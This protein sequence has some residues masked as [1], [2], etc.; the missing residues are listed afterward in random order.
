VT[1]APA[2][3]AF[4]AIGRGEIAV[5]LD[6]EGVGHLLR[7]ARGTSPEDVVAM[8]DAGGG[9]FSVV[10]AAARCQELRI[11]EQPA[12]ESTRGSRRIGVSVDAKEGTTTGISAGDR[13]LT[14]QAVADPATRASDLVVPGHVPPLIAADAGVLAGRGVAEA[15]LDL[16]RLAGG[17]GALAICAML[18]EDG[19][20]ETAEEVSATAARSGLPLVTVTEIA[21]R[22]IAAERPVRATEHRRVVTHHGAFTAVSLLNEETGEGHAA[23]VRGEVEGRREVPLAIRTSSPVDDLLLSLAPT[24]E[25]SLVAVLRRFARAESGILIHLRDADPEDP[26]ALDL[27]AATLLELGPASVL[28]LDPAQAAPLRERGIPVAPPRTAPRRRSNGRCGDFDYD[29]D[30]A[31]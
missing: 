29:V 20:T 15:A 14:A 16:G 12:R 11:P 6:D 27:A 19:A 28:P 7:D 24:G 4:E 31:I 30:T 2:A 21:A 10:L 18:D 3:A 1:G 5:L 25:S 13:A 23:L 17:S 9:I 8:L 26:R 22:R